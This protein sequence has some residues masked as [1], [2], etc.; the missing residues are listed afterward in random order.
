MKKPDSSI[1]E[2]GPF[3]FV[4]YSHRDAPAAYLEI[5]RFQRAGI[6]VWY[7]EGIEGGD[8]WADSVAA[9]ITKSTVFFFFVT[10]NSVQSEHCRREINF[11]H[12]CATAV[13]PIYL[14]PTTLP[15]GLK[16]SL[17]NRQ[18]IKK[19]ELPEWK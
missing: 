7:D 1:V 6:R 12:D 19:Y 18:A 13:T 15:A 16:L 3:A 9:A 4:C 5:Q 11:A 2:S 17:S 8:E 10:E 14:E